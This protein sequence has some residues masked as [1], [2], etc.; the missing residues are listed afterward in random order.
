MA[1]IVVLVV[2]AA[3]LLYGYKSAAEVTMCGGTGCANVTTCCNITNDPS[4]W[5]SGD[6]TWL[7]CHA[8]AFAEGADVAGSNPDRLNNPGDVSDGYLTYGG[9]LHSGSA[10]THFPNKGVGWQWLYD[11]ITNIVAGKSVEYSAN[12]TWNA[13]AQKYSGDWKAWVANVTR[14][15]NVAPTSTLNDYMNS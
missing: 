4:T 5:P 13:F 1:T 15:L 10:V 6:R 8:I 14:T 12:D 9:E 2:I 3:L 7:V 11:K